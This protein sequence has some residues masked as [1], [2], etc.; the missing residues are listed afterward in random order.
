MPKRTATRLTLAL[1]GL[2]LAGSLALAQS[3]LTLNPF[4]GTGYHQ[5]TDAEGNTISAMSDPNTP[6]YASRGSKPAFLAPDGHHLTFGEFDRVQGLAVANCSGAGTHLTLNLKGLLPD[7][8][9][10][11]WLIVREHGMDGSPVLV[12]LGSFGAAAGGDSQLIVAADGTS[13]ISVVQP[14]GSLSTSVPPQP[15]ASMD[16]R[17]VVGSCLF[18]EA[19]FEAHVIYHN[20]G[21][22]HGDYPG[23]GETWATQAAFVFSSP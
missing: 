23:S 8:I 20:D 1:L 11:V 17:Y 10:T 19:I 5:I 9:Y 21:L 13:S 6:L 22:M 18:E 12:G 2:A 3:G 16:E 15:E 14:A 7:G 4:V